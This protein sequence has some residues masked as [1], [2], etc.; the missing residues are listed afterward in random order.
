MVPIYVSMNGKDHDLPTNNCSDSG[1]VPVMESM[2]EMVWRLT[3]C[4]ISSQCFR[5]Q[6]QSKWRRRSYYGLNSKPD[7][8]P[9]PDSDRVL[10]DDSKSKSN[11]QRA[12]RQ[13][14]KLMEM[15]RDRSFRRWNAVDYGSERIK[16]EPKERRTKRTLLKVRK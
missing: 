3:D 16:L 2:E 1:T 5:P 9:P 13:R 10:D 12:H 6:F 11:S 7:P 14:L 15:E 4:P 8:D